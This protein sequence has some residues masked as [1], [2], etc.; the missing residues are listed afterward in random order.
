MESK[1]L[2]FDEIRVAKNA[3]SLDPIL[4]ENEN[5]I[6][7][8]MH[9][10]VRF[11]MD[12][13]V[14]ETVDSPNCVTRIWHGDEVMRKVIEAL[15]EDEYSVELSEKVEEDGIMEEE[16][17]R[18]VAEATCQYCGAGPEV[19][20]RWYSDNYGE[21]SNCGAHKLYGVMNVI[22]KEKEEWGVPLSEGG[23]TQHE[24]E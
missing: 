24:G 10:E 5:K 9:G 8:T 13:D 20:W 1:D 14:K 4:K 21:C 18:V 19:G 23:V 15:A 2:G 3:G 22:L 12:L 16:D 11:F 17:P 6:M 7:K